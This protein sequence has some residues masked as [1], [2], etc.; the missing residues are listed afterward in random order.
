MNSE[1][2][3]SYISICEMLHSF[4]CVDRDILYRLAPQEG[5]QC[6]ESCKGIVKYSS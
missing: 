2:D 3:E 4:P 5:I 1:K 6:V